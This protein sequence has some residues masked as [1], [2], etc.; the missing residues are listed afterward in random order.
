MAHGGVVPHSSSFELSAHQMPTLDDI[1]KVYLAM[2]ATMTPRRRI[3]TGKGRVR[4]HMMWLPHHLPLGKG[5][6]RGHMMCLTNLP[7][8]LDPK[9]ELR[10][11]LTINYWEHELKFERDCWARRESHWAASGSSI[12]RVLVGL[13]LMHAPTHVMRVKKKR[14]TGTRPRAP[15]DCQSVNQSIS[16]SV[17][18]VQSDQSVQSVQ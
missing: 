15:H 2:M 17:Q 7:R 1:C 3:K 8:I 11:D 13:R 4:G 6:E 10:I 18:S 14:T 12:S 9:R 16:Q 5:V